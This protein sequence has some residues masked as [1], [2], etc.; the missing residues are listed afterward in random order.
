MNQNGPSYETIK[1]MMEAF[2][3]RLVVTVYDEIINSLNAAAAAAE[4]GEIEAR[5]VATSRAADLVTELHLA[6]D[7]KQGGEIAAALSD[8]YRLVLCEIPNI[9][10][11]NDAALARRLITILEPLR[12]AWD[13]LDQ[14][15]EEGISAFEGAGPAGTI[16]AADRAGLLGAA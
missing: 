15:I 14:R 11:G 2:P 1:S 4:V 7:M 10:I 3:S 16:A 13:E 12:S 5:F 8:I 6:L 9:N